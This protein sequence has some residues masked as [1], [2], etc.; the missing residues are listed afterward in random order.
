M[1]KTSTTLPAAELQALPPTCHLQ[2]AVDECCNCTYQQVDSLNHDKLHPLLSEL[3]TTPFFRYFKVNVFCDCPL[4]PDDSMCAM[5]ACSVCECDANE[6]PSSWLAQ[7]Q[8]SCAANDTPSAAQ[9]ELGGE[10]SP[11]A[12]PCDT[13][14]CAAELDSRVNSSVEPAIRSQLLALKGWRGIN[15]PWMAEADDGEEYLYINLRVNPERYTGYKGEHAHR[16]WKAIYSQSCFARVDD[17][18]EARVFYRLVSGMHASI[19]AHISANYLLDEEGFGVT[20]GKNLTD[21][22]HR[23]GTVGVRERVQNLYFAYLFVLRAVVKA[24][25]LLQRLDY[26]TGLAKE[27][28]RTQELI[29]QL[30]SMPEL[31]QACPMPFDEG[32]LWKGADSA[33]LMAEVQSAFQNI[34]RIMD[35]V[36]CEKCK[37]WGKLQTLGIATALKILFSSSDCTGAVPA[38]GSPFAVLQLERNEVIALLNLLERFAVALEYYDEMSQD[39]LMG[40]GSKA[41][42]TP[43]VA[44]AVAQTEAIF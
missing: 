37:L 40:G 32:R 31:Q 5:Q 1:I 11:T 4:W 24:G 3:V 19:S 36:G 15:N 16:I 41:S 33:V 18:A 42:L 12:P 30:V 26:F 28:A 20:W 25:P 6:V 2:G 27:D 29:D 9:G 22:Q 38:Q 43:P 35:C 17:C 21:F 23:L 7:E 44:P 34:T 13:A 14:Q 8:A 39:M 10:S